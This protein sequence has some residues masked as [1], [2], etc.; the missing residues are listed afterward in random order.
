M[1]LLYRWFYPSGVRPPILLRTL[2]R[3]HLSSPLLAVIS[4]MSGC[5]LVS[6]NDAPPTLTPFPVSPGWELIAPGLER[7]T[8]NPG[9]LFVSFTALR[10]DPAYFDIRAHY[11]PGEPLT[12]EQW[13]SRLP[14]AMAFIN[15]NFFDPSGYALGLVI[16]DGVAYGR[17]YLDRGGMLYV[18]DGTPKVRSTLREPYQGEAIEYAAQA[19]PMLVMDGQAVFINERR[20]RPSRRTVVGEDS[21]GRIVLLASSSLIGMRLTDLSAY[22]PTTDLDLVNAVNLDGGGSTLL[23]LYPPQGNAALTPSFDPIPVVIAVYPR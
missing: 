9:S 18:Q 12:L 23:A 17:S 6:A 7:R 22:L 8:Y 11:S 13:R 21:Q 19:F 14:D 20:D 3:V 2:H 15:A 4:L 1:K 5:M 16:V 10:I